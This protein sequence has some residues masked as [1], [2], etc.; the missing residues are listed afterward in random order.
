MKKNKKQ[1]KNFAPVFETQ[2]ISEKKTS[3]NESNVSI[4]S[5]SS[6]K[7]AKDWVAHNQK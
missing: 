6:V 4:P 7:E 1:N 3:L 2:P 5:E